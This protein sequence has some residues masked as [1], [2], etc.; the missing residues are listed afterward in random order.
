[1]F[2]DLAGEEILDVRIL[3]NPFEHDHSCSTVAAFL[4]EQGANVVLAGGLGRNAHGH[5]LSRG[6][7]ALSGFSGGVEE[8]LRSWMRG[9]R[10]RP[11]LCEHHGHEE[12][13]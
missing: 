13:H 4:D 3:A 8:C 11:A 2:V 10:P 7:E 9:E 5:L 1:V 12:H 6:I